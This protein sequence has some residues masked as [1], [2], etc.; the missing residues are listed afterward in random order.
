MTFQNSKFAALLVFAAVLCFIVG[1]SS[2][3]ANKPVDAG[4]EGKTP[5]LK[6]G[7]V[8]HD[9]QI[10]LFIAA[11]EGKR[12]QKEYG[13]YLKE[14]KPRE[15]YDLIEGG[16]TLAELHIIKVGGGARMPAAMER[17]EIDVGYGGVAAVAFFRDKG[18]PMKILC[19]LQTEG[20]ML[21]VRPDLPADDW[22]SFVKY[23]KSS[24]KPLKIGYKAPVAV[25]KLIFMRALKEEGI[26]Y[27]VLGGK[28]GG[29][30]A[31][32]GSVELVNLQGGK[33]M[34]PS[35]S[36][37]AVDGFVMNQPQV[38]MAKVKK[39]GKV[40]A[41]LADLPPAGKWKDH[42]C[43][44]IVAQEEIIKAHRPVL[45]ALMKLTLLAT[46]WINAD[47]IRAAGLAAKW[48]KIPLDVEKDS[49][50]SIIFLAEFTDSWNQGMIVWADIMD[51][52]GKFTK[53]L[54]GKTGD[55]F[56]G[57]IC[58]TSL[59]EE[60]SKELREKGHLK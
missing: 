26:S 52:I 25:A 7:H 33:N 37:G 17:G 27:R 40:I 13:I 12:F 57:I 51:E 60:A 15:V 5:I 23:I 9:H 35:L 22:N 36:S 49:V 18:N 24:P 54:K 20:D 58:D 55:E 19:P 2:D 28:A 21:V 42:P 45:K 59:I 53:D 39:I 50:P 29:D 14:K 6:V 48:T 1:C 4:K 56:L 32:A 16:K 34:V 44:C 43:C 11:L 41:E 8:G 31:I 46:E 10:A 47:K 38:S 3:S 30:E